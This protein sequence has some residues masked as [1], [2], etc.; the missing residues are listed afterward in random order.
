MKTRLLTALLIL[1][2]LMVFAQKP[3][4]KPVGRYKT[5]QICVAHEKD[6]YFYLLLALKS[7]EE[8]NCS[9]PL[10]GKSLD[11]YEV[12]EKIVNRSNKN[13]KIS[14]NPFVGFSIKNSYQSCKKLEQDR[15]GTGRGIGKQEYIYISARSEKFLDFQTTIKLAQLP[16]D[17]VTANFKILEDKEH[18]FNPISEKEENDLILSRLNL[19][20]CG[21]QIIL[22]PPIDEASMLL[23]LK[24]RKEMLNYCPEDYPAL[25]FLGDIYYQ[26]KD[27]A[28]MNWLKLALKNYELSIYHMKNSLEEPYNRLEL[29]L[30]E[31]HW[32]LA[33]LYEY[34]GLYEQAISYFNLLKK[35]SP[36]Y[37]EQREKEILNQYNFRPYDNSY[38]YNKINYPEEATAH[39]ILCRYLLKNRPTNVTAA[40][41]KDT[42]ISTAMIERLD[43]SDEAI[44]QRSGLEPVKEMVKQVEQQQQYKTKD[45]SVKGKIID[46]ALMALSWAVAP[47]DMKV[48]QRNQF[49]MGTLS[50]LVS[51]IDKDKINANGTSSMMAD[52]A[53]LPSSPVAKNAEAAFNK[54]EPSSKTN[55]VAAT[56]PKKIETAGGVTITDKWDVKDMSGIYETLERS[57]EC[58]YVG[59]TWRTG[60]HSIER[61]TITIK[62][63]ELIQQGKRIKFLSTGTSTFNGST[64]STYAEG[65]GIILNNKCIIKGLVTGGYS[66]NINSKFTPYEFTNEIEIINEFT[67]KL[68]N[69]STIG[70]AA[71]EPNCIYTFKKK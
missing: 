9:C 35:Y 18:Q 68:R 33:N 62:P 6:V 71:I 23:D 24:Y 8:C 36:Q 52:L 39:I 56:E 51:L 54:M 40:L 31:I 53:G 70:K 69:T 4:T 67:F 48:E 66:G 5:I 58:P 49:I 60:I 63:V 41:E 44:Q 55:P 65:E 28:D 10:K 34:A 17:N 43:L 64:V 15:Y 61:A 42:V 47:K 20:D 16:S 45:P 29:C 14:L 3:K 22:L 30:L 57:G 7:S 13:I 2:N 19:Q 1:L 26:E 27:K 46:V 50:A 37:I 38:R 11:E 32:K 59:S 21:D 12:Y 25:K